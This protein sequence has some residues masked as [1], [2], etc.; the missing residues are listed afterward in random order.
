MC[1]P[2]VLLSKDGPETG[3]HREQLPKALHSLVLGAVEPSLPWPAETGEPLRKRAPPGDHELPLE[4][5]QRQAVLTM[6]KADRDT[7]I[8]LE[9]G[10]RDAVQDL[11]LVGLFLLLKLDPLVPIGSHLN[12]VS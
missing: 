9:T 3:Q 5:E 2:E 7:I 12:L 8:A 1:A 4:S 6:M 11:L 10:V